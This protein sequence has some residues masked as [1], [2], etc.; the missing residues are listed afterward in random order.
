MENYA[1]EAAE[2]STKYQMR[3]LEFAVNHH[4]WPDV[5][6]FDFTSMYAAENASRMIERKGYKLLAILVGD[7]LLEVMSSWSIIENANI[8]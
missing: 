1:L 8:T 2:F 5:A 3:D 4:G 7:S 6:M